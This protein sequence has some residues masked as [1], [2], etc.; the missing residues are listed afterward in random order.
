VEK[1]VTPTSVATAN[2][3]STLT[4]TSHFTATNCYKWR[5]LG[6]EA[7]SNAGGAG[8][9]GQILSNTVPVLTLDRTYRVVPTGTIT[10]QICDTQDYC[11]ANYFLPY[12]VATYLQLDNVDTEFIWQQL[13]DMYQT[14]GSGNIKN[15]YKTNESLLKHYIQKGRAVFDAKVMDQFPK[16]SRSLFH[17]FHLCFVFLGVL[18]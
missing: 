6:I 4:H 17:I 8:Y 10:Y 16:N 9:I 1:N 14:R 5:W 15:L 13:L 3:V 2:G 7:A 18:V 12:A 11:L